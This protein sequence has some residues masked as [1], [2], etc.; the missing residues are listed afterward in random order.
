MRP[1]FA[2]LLFGVYRPT[3]PQA[4][5]RARESSDLHLGEPRIRLYLRPEEIDMS[6]GCEKISL[7][8]SKGAEPCHHDGDQAKE[9]N[10]N[11][12]GQT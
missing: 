1:Q 9:R 2:G 11:A 4:A 8:R 10:H 3:D 6:L 5:T 12:P 7:L